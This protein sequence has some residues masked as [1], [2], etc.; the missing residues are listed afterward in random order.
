MCLIPKDLPQK[1][2][3]SSFGHDLRC[4]MGTE[5]VPWGTMLWWVPCHGDGH[6]VGMDAGRGR[7]TSLFSI[8]GLRTTGKHQCES[9][10]GLY[11]EESCHTYAMTLVGRCPC[12]C[13]PAHS[14][15]TGCNALLKTPVKFPLLLNLLTRQGGKL[16]NSNPE[17]LSLVDWK[18]S[19]GPLFCRA[20]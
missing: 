14:V 11:Q 9:C 5:H 17:A 16:L 3:S 6:P 15:D 13:I 12:G 7:G 8:R 1:L 10:S 2:A 19:T 18:L 20:Y 4:R